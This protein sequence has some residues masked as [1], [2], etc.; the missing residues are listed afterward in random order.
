MTLLLSFHFRSMPPPS[1]PPI[2]HPP[3]L[4]SSFDNGMPRMVR[5]VYI[6]DSAK[7]VQLTVSV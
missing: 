2:S 6:R 4:P 1:G 7:V 5:Y 3:M